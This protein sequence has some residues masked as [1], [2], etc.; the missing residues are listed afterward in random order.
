[1]KCL[2]AI[3][4]ITAVYRAN[5]CAKGEGVVVTTARKR[6]EQKRAGVPPFPYFA[7]WT[8]YLQLQCAH[9]TRVLG[10]LRIDIFL[11]N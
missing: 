8:D 6:A 2:F 11:P 1:M 5:S 10:R 7:L 9:S 4:S 3:N